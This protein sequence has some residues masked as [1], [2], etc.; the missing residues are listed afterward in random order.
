[1]R[2]GSWQP[3]SLAQVTRSPTPMTFSSQTRT[4]SLKYSYQ[5]RETLV[6]VCS[7]K[8]GNLS[9][10]RFRR[11]DGNRKLNLLPI[12]LSHRQ[13]QP[14][15]LCADFVLPI[16]TS[17]VKREFCLNDFRAFISFCLQFLYLVIL[18]ILFYHFGAFTS[19]CQVFTRIFWTFLPP[20][21]R[22]LLRNN[23]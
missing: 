20:A 15:R 21:W 5:Q 10:R 18:K 6:P 12:H 7:P 13:G 23:L 22:W 2:V 16:L 1:M 9:T 4:S 17:P 14:S 11:G 8:L 3:T 19:D